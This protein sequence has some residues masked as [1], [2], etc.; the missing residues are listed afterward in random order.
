MPFELKIFVLLAI[1][2]M[3]QMTI[4]ANNISLLIVLPL[5]QTS[6][7][8]V[9]WEKGLEILPGALQAVSDINN[10]SVLLPGHTLKLIAVDSERDEFKI[11]QQ[12]IN[13]MFYG[14]VNIVGIGGILDP[15][16]VSILLPLVERKRVLIST[17]THTDKL[18][19]G[20][21]GYSGAYLPLPSPS[22]MASVLLNFVREMNWKYVGLVTDTKSVYFSGVAETLWQTAAINDGLT[23]SPYIESSHAVSAIK[24]IVKSKVKIIIMSLS[25]EATI[26]FLCAVQEKG[27]VWPQ[28]AWVLHSFQAKDLLE[29]QTACVIEDTINGVF[30]IN[31]HLRSD[32]VQAE[33]KS[34][35]TSLNYYQPYL[36]SL[37]DTSLKHNDTLRPNG[38][39]KLLYD[40]VWAM[41][42]ALNTSY[43]HNDTRTDPQ[44]TAIEVLESHRGHIDWVFRIFQIR[45]LQQVFISTMHYNNNSCITTTSFNLS[46][47]ENAPK[48]ELPI[49][50]LNPPLAYTVILG[51][52]IVLLTTFVTLTLVLYVHFRKEPE[53][54]ATSFT[55]SL[56][57]FVGCYLNLL[58][59]SLLLYI[60]H[61]FDSYNIARDNALCLSLQWLSGP[62]IPL[63]LML[64]T[65][66]VKMLRIYHVFY[67]TKLHR[68]GRRCSDLALALYVL[69][70]LLPDIFV[71]LI[72]TIVDPYQIHVEYRMQKGCLYLEKSCRSNYKKQLFGLL[73][74]Y[75]LILIIALLV[76]AIITRKVRLQHFKDTKKVNILL[77]ILGKGIIITFC[78]WILLQIIYTERYIAAL[79]VY[80]PHSVL[81]LSFQGLLVVPKVFPP[82]WRCVKTFH[83]KI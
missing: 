50:P 16:A 31:V 67:S 35:V 3:L 8:R 70:I 57:I 52:Q 56:L 55:L 81:I 65:L 14:Q 28:Y 82:L 5:H 15:K 17:I 32:S 24:D 9:S 83:L 47:L 69:L 63:P 25:A 36:S 13:L 45:N 49:V 59:L 48:G 43:Y 30:F 18:G 40:L 11:V 7:P 61:T 74:A 4:K 42:F 20:R 26:K 34:G 2:S 41:A 23:L 75:L 38:Y 80:I 77:F 6:G 10:D 68:I 72:W 60:H 19:L 62:G 33:L 46:T 44:A 76:V 53:I 64:A 22:A 54:K 79:S 39:A 51:L 29:L 73:S 71:N 1:V 12:F 21:L 37:S 27:L 58:Y 78:Y 66:L